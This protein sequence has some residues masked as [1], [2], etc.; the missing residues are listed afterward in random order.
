MNILNTDLQ[1]YAIK[2]RYRS[3]S[4]LFI[5]QEDGLIEAIKKDDVEHKGI[6]YIKEFDPVKCSFV[7]ISKEI[8]LN[9]YSHNAENHNYLKNHYYFK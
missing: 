3:N 7:R 1:T 5:C 8:I 4:S 9:R 2:L 6:D